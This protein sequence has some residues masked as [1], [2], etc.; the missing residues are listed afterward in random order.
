MGSLTLRCFL[1]FADARAETEKAR[2]VVDDEAE[3]D[4]DATFATLLAVRK[5]DRRFVA[6]DMTGGQEQLFRECVG[7]CNVVTT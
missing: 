7:P 1:G 5:D 6:K 4:E 2:I 3:E